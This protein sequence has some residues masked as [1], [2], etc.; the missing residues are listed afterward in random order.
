MTVPNGLK[1]V[2]ST[3]PATI[4]DTHEMKL[5]TAVKIEWNAENIPDLYEIL[6]CGTPYVEKDETSTSI[7]EI[8]TSGIKLYTHDNQLYVQAGSPITNLA[9]YDLFGRTVAQAT[10]HST[11]VEMTLGSKHAPGTHRASNRRCT[12]GLDSQNRVVTNNRM[13]R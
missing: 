9:L 13:N 3:P 6:P 10:P 4:L 12:G 11:Q 1:W 7:E 8:G 5:V 2:I